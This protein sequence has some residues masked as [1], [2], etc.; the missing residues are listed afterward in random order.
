MRIDTEL[1]GQGWGTGKSGF[2]GGKSIVGP[3]GGGGGVSVDDVDISRGDDG[4]S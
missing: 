4:I 1:I 2:C 3:S